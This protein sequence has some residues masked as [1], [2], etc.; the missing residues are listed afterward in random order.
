MGNA[1]H[2]L[3][4]IDLRAKLV[5]SLNNSGSSSSSCG[6]YDVFTSKEKILLAQF[7]ELRVG[8]KFKKPPKFLA[9]SENTT[10]RIEKLY[11]KGATYIDAGSLLINIACTLKI[12]N[13]SI[14]PNFS[15]CMPTRT[16][17]FYNSENCGYIIHITPN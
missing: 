4:K 5:A 11:Y 9:V 6:I 7:A 16:E 15:L 1:I 12:D 2:K 10:I 14:V 13:D 8:R 3:N 17:I